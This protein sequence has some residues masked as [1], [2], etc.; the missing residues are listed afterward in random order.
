MLYVKLK[1]AFFRNLQ[2]ALL[3]CQ[4]LSKTLMEWWFNLNQ[5]DPCAAKKT[6]NGKQFTLIWN[7]DDLRISHVKEKGSRRHN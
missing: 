1:R 4:L 3:F 7:V 6:T 2:A 5:Y